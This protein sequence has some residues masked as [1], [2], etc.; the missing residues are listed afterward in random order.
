MGKFI[1]V[2]LTIISSIVVISCTTYKQPAAV[3]FVDQSQIVG[4]QPIPNDSCAGINDGVTQCRSQNEQSMCQAC[5]SG[6]WQQLTL[7]SGYIE[8]PYGPTDTTFECNSNKYYIGCNYYEQQTL[9]Q[10]QQQQLINQQQQRLAQYRQKLQE[11]ERLAEQ[12]KEQLQQQQRLAQYRYQQQYLERL[13]QQQKSLPN[14][15]NYNYNSDPYFN[16]APSYRYSRSGRY[17]E[18]NQYGA[19]LL[20]QAITY[21]YEQGFRA[22]QADREDGWGYNYQDTYAYQ[23]ANYGYNGFY[24]DQ[25]D[26][27]Y[28]YREGFSRGYDDGYNNR[29][30]YG[31]YSNGNY[32]VQGAV[33]SQILNLQSLR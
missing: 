4:T 7:G 25:N 21:G 19:N 32:S 6:V 16:T 17:Y 8:C 31:S 2:Y 23:D 11:Q 26:Y 20:K 5:C 10:Q 15:Q 18:T 27:N 22:G 9:S 3:N 28:Y 24:V 13:S 1:I 14:E 12:R 29:Y 33:M 30:Q